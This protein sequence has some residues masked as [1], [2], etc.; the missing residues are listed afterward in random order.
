MSDKKFFKTPPLMT[1]GQKFFLFVLIAGVLYLGQ[2]RS[3]YKNERD[4]KAIA[5]YM[6]CVKYPRT[7]EINGVNKEMTEGNGIA[8]CIS[9]NELYR[10]T[11]HFKN[12]LEVYKQK[13]CSDRNPFN[14]DVILHSKIVDDLLRLAKEDLYESDF[15]YT[16]YNQNQRDAYINETNRVEGESYICYY[17]SLEDIR[18]S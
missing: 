17:A 15:F 1:M 18:N 3:E 5:D 7:I 16:L 9:R 10:T 14:R 12:N 8:I 4:S 11:D 2:D 13:V 6:S